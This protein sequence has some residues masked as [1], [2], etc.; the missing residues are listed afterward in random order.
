MLI[1]TARDAGKLIRAGRR[2]AN[3]TQVQLAQ[4]L[5]CTQKWVSQ[6]EN[7]RPGADLDRVLRALAVLKVTVHGRLPGA[8]YPLPPGA[9]LVDRVADSTG[10]SDEG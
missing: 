5:G 10:T 1:R 9:G 3:L 8:P 6:I 4:K 7:G 2:A